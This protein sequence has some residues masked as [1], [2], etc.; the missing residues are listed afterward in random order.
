MRGGG[1]TN[2]DLTVLTSLDLPRIQDWHVRR[3]KVADVPRNHCEIVFEGCRRHQTVDSRQRSSLTFGFGSQ[4]SP[5]IRDYLVDCQNSS[6]KSNSYIQFE[7]TLKISAPLALG[8][9]CRARPYFPQRQHTQV[10]Q[11]LVY[12]PHPLHNARIRPGT[13]QFRDAI[14]IEQKPAHKTSLRA[15]LRSRLRLSFNP[16]IGD[17]RKKSTM[18]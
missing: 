15:G 3:C 7:P 10:Q 11:A 1:E 9:D 18:F 6:R 4:P 2:R 16:I 17:C 12:L 5:A 14:G 8:K 13:N